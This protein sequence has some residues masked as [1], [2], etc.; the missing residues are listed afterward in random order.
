MALLAECVH[1][2]ESLWHPSERVFVTGMKKREREQMLRII[3]P[4]KRQKS[5]APLR[6]RVLQSSLPADVKSSIFG[7]LRSF[8]GG[9]KEVREKYVR[10]VERALAL[11]RAPA[12]PSGEEIQASLSRAKEAMDLAVVG[13]EPV[14]R[15]VLQLLCQMRS[16]STRRGYALGLE[17]PAGTGKTHFVQHAMGKALGLPVVTIPMGGC[18]DVSYL[19]GSPYG[20]E[21]GEEGRL[22]AALAEANCSNPILHLDEVDK[23][24]QSE[25]GQEVVG[26]LVHLLDPMTNGKLRDRYFHGIDLDFSMCTVVLTYNDAS[27]LSPVLLDRV[28]RRYMAPLPVDERRTVILSHIVPKLV[29]RLGVPLLSLDGSAV[30]CILERHG[31]VRDAEKDVECILSG[32][33]LRHL[34]ENRIPAYNV[35]ADEA[36]HLLS[37]AGVPLVRVEVNPPPPHGMYT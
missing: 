27:R 19:L 6:I 16:G 7:E 22:S 13:H 1:A 31:N 17:G 3:L 23:I 4:N 37:L 24:S 12:L 8:E 30:D 34:Q 25:R 32:S 29:A 10:W 36:R 26:A 35:G 21:G 15:E 11:P 2:E 20:C 18:T 28:R 9:G 33:Q 14:K 5:K